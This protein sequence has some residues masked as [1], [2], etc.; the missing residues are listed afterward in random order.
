MKTGQLI[1]EAMQS[2]LDDLKASDSKG[3]DTRRTRVLSL[4]SEAYEN[5]SPIAAF[6]DA[7]SR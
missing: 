6:E 1:L 3:F 7:E 2:V 4:L 5:Y